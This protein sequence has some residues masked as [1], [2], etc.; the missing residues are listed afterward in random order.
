MTSAE[1]TERWKYIHYLDMNGADEIYDL[2][3]DPFELR[4][5]IADPRAPK[6]A[7]EERLVRLLRS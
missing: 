2:R 4:N 6:K 5:M 1:G 7:L 3:S